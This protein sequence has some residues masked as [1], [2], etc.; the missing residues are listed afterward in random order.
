M[1][2]PNSIKPT[3]SVTSIISL[4]NPGA[5]ALTMLMF[6][7]LLIS[8]CESAPN[9]TLTSQQVNPDGSNQGLNQ[10]S[11]SNQESQH[12]ISGNALIKNA[13]IKI[14]FV[15][16]LTGEAANYGTDDL[17]GALLA[18]EELNAAGGINGRPLQVIPEDDKCSGKD[19]TTAVSKLLEVDQVKVVLG[20]SCSGATLSMAPI[21]E[22][23][24][25]LLMT[26]ISTNAKI[27]YAGDFVFRNGP[28]DASTG[29]MLAEIAS[30]N[31]KRVALISENTEY[32]Q[33]IREVFVN[34]AKE[35]GLE[36][37]ADE[38][39]EPSNQ[40]FKT[41]LTKIKGT[42]PEA[43]FINPQSDPTVG[44][45]LKQA[46]E[47][48]LNSQ[49]LV[50]WYG[51]SEAFRKAAGQGNAEGVIWVDTPTID[52]ANQRGMDLLAKHTK[53]FGKA[54]NFPFW[55]G[56]TYDRVG[57]LGEAMKACDENPN[58]KNPENTECIRDWF[59][60]MK[61]YNG[62]TGH[63]TFDKD[64]EE[65]GISLQGYQLVKGKNVVLK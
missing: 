50:A 5:A 55:L 46:R 52:E 63:F 34:R 56:M 31:W 40:D 16:P 8:A 20:S 29:A 36:V 42:N 24:K 15:G 64:G 30:K 11:H 53:K 48:G 3:K 6:A 19:A 23:A 22:K 32:A 18:V 60:T 43:L 14:G 4:I 10:D 28:N 12:Q 57:V 26:S 39:A 7:L 45:I 25:A 65:E 21:T 47:L 37:V 2:K 35:L 61:P 27:R 51:A 54:P 58:I 49:V 33:G 44:L 38:R 13:P 62:V 17:N 41:Q 9:Q 1:V 59:Y